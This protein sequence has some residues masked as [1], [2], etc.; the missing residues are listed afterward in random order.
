MFDADLL[1]ANLTNEIGPPETWVGRC[2][3]VANLMNEKL[4]LDLYLAYGAYW[5]YVDK[6]SK[7]YRKGCSVYRHGWLETYSH[8]PVI[9]DPTR[10]VFEASVP[11]IYIGP[12]RVQQLS[13]GV[14]VYDPGNDILRQVT[15][16]TVKT[17]EIDAETS[18]LRPLTLS[19][20][21][22][23]EFV[24]SQTGLDPDK[25]TVHHVAAL[26][27]L[28]RKVLG[29]LARP[30]YLSIASIGLQ[31]FVPIDNFNY[32]VVRVGEI[33]RREAAQLEE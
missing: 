17:T 27:N 18:K 12:N 22:T 16:T 28:P 23:V 9:V 21:E 6:R 30:I 31:G 20:P 8:S 7:L 24:R 33:E 25:L 29:H 26:A 15:M 13:N 11:Y 5:G 1:L 2:H 32:E 19:D 14:P 10:W 3:E 4:Q